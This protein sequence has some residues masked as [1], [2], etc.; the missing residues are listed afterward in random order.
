M[1]V[2][3]VRMGRI[4]LDAAGHTGPA[5]LMGTPGMFPKLVLAQH[6]NFNREQEQ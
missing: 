4:A 1:G 6:S 2:R 3:E 5:L